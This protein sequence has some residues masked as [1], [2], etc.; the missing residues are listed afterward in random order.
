MDCSFRPILAMESSVKLHCVI[1]L[2]HFN[3]VRDSA[4]E[5]YVIPPWN[6]VKFH[7]FPPFLT[8]SKPTFVLCSSATVYVQVHV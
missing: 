3:A 2:S 5:F 8:N 4:M 6:H 7:M 1:P